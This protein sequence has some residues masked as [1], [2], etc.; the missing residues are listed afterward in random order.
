[1]TDGQ[2]KRRWLLPSNIINLATLFIKTACYS[3][4]KISNI[5]S[6]GSYWVEFKWSQDHWLAGGLPKELDIYLPSYSQTTRKQIIKN[7]F[8]YCSTLWISYCFSVQLVP[9]WAGFL[10]VKVKYSKKCGE[11]TFWRKWSLLFWILLNCTNQLPVILKCNIA[12]FLKQWGL[13]SRVLNLSLK[14]MSGRPEPL[15]QCNLWYKA[16]L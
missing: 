13:Y 4:S 3:S 5:L 11:V 1:M 8:L 12:E 15:E 7:N 16:T 6:F 9:F 2:S 10:Q 14:A